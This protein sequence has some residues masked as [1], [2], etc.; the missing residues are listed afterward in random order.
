MAEPLVTQGSPELSGDP[1]SPSLS[2]SK[3]PH[4]RHRVFPPPDYV[5]NLE[6]KLKT[7]RKQQQLEHHRHVEAILAEAATK[8]SSD[9]DIS[10][11][12]NLMKFGDDVKSR[13]KINIGSSAD[14]ESKHNGT[15][16]K[17]RPTVSTS[18]AL[19]LPTPTQPVL[20]TADSEERTNDG[21]KENGGMFF[22]E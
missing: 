7:R 1:L 17:S 6:E 18:P 19:P 2:Q 8:G 16:T 10:T 11:D 22:G 15:I 9:S 5:A 3:Q 20:R 13:S 12:S 4:H 21:A 14:S